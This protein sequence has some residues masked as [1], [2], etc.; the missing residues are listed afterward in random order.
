MPHGLPPDLVLPEPRPLPAGFA[1]RLAGIV[2]TDHVELDPARR[3]EASRD[4]AWLSPVLTARLPDVVADL[5]VAPGSTAE[6]AAV[7]GAAHEAGVPITARG[8]GTGNYGQAVPLAAG[9]VVETDRM[10]AVRDVGDGW[11]DAGP[12]TSF[13]RLEAAARRHGQQLRVFPSTVSSTIGGFLAGGAGGTGSIE[14][15]FLWDGRTVASVDVLPCWDAPEVATFLG[16]DALPYVHTY[17]TT[18]VVAGARVLTEPARSWTAVLAGFDDVGSAGRAGLAV[19]ALDPVPRN[20]SVDDAALVGCLPADDAMPA[21]RASL[22]SIV[23]T[24]AVDAHLEVVR[25]MGGRIEAVRPDGAGQLVSL[26]FNHVTL[27]AKRVRPALC[28]LQVGGEPLVEAPD[29]VRAVLPGAMLHLDGRGPAPDVGFGGLLLSEFVDVDTLYEGVDRL[30]D[31]GVFVVDPHT[32]MLG[33]HGGVDELRSVAAH[34]DPAGLLNPGKI[35]PSVPVA[36]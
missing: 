7:I 28:H 36:G 8:K 1:D 2:G 29:D 16:D 31:I 25:S 35:P 17:G 34:Q 22:R 23:A 30:R 10:N 12:G 26:S 14:H 24:D 32:W 3:L 6:L 13:V 15:G 33:G 9:M 21:G 4:H 11:I 27:R 5:V 18:G 19:M 20:V